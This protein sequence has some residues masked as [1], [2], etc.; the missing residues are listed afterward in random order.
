MALIVLHTRWTM[1]GTRVLCYNG[2][3][4]WDTQEEALEELAEEESLEG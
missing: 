4:M 3:V 2:Q 1:S